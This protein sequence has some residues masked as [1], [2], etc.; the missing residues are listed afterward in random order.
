MIGFA[1]SWKGSVGG[2]NCMKTA[3]TGINKPVN[4]RGID[5]VIHNIATNK[6]K[7][8]ARWACWLLKM[9]KYNMTLKTSTAIRIPVKFIPFFNIVI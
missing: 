4:G 7:A 3:N 6:S 9:G 8:S 5:S 2:S 1:N